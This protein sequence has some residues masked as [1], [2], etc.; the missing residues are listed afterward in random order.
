M[1]TMDVIV[2]VK[3]NGA[4]KRLRYRDAYGLRKD[5]DT[6]RFTGRSGKNYEVQ[7]DDH[8]SIMLQ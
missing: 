7:L 3:E 1:I 5:G 2:I 6:V 8:H 4:K